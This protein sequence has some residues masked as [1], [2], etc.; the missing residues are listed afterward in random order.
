MKKKI[1]NEKL[2]LCPVCNSSS[3]NIEISNV[4]DFFF[5]S[6]DDEWSFYNCE[7]CKSFFLNPRPIE[8]N[9]H[10]AYSNYYTHR[11]ISINNKIKSIFF[12]K[13]YNFLKKNIYK[14]RFFLDDLEIKKGDILDIGCGDGKL[15]DNLGNEWKK[16][17]IEFD[18]KAIKIARD[19]KLKIYEGGYKILSSIDKKFDVIIASHVLE[20]IHSPFNFIELAFK[21]LKKGGEMWLQWPAPNSYLYNKYKS[22]WRGLEA[23]RH[24]SLPSVSSLDI[25]LR[26]K[27]YSKF[28]LNDFSIKWKDSYVYLDLASKSAKNGNKG[29]ISRY[30]L[31][32]GYT[33]Y[34]FFKHKIFK[35]E[36]NTVVI[37]KLNHD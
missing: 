34:L 5:E 27:F 10:L 15:L 25:I 24:L 17:G 18:E 9:I 12:K 32:I 4:K 37:K 29:I 1:I 11:S 20:H 30:D 35:S 3:I 28:I 7:N 23:P 8:K 22:Y 21:N 16:Y 33:K 6:S 14:K 13:I 26:K 19:K 36:F 31:L 2:S